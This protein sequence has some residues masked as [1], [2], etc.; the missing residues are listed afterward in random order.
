MTRTICVAHYGGATCET[1]DITEVAARHNHIMLEDE[2]HGLFAKHFAK[3]SVTFGSMT[4][5][6]SMRLKT[7]HAVKVVHY[8]INDRSLVERAE[9]PREK[10]TNRSKFLRGQVDKCRMLFRFMNKPTYTVAE[11]TGP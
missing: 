8:I 4:Q 10:S 2:A 5:R 3:C 7:S 1:E 6:A 11:R 9:I